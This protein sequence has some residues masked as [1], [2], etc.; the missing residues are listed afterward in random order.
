MANGR[1]TKAFQHSDTGKIYPAGSEVE[2]EECHPGQRVIRF[3]DGH[4]KR[5][6][7]RT[8]IR[9]VN[10]FTGARTK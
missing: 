8:V 6:N 1:T 10:P 5:V 9:T 4:A 7:A 3:S 2:I